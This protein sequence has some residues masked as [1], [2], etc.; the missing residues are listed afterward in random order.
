MDDMIELMDANGLL[1]RRLEAYA[2]FRLSPDLATTSRLRARVLAVAHR[3][4]SLARADAA[5]SVLP[6]ADGRTSG[7]LARDRGRA[8]ARHRSRR[9]SRAAG[10]FLAASLATAIVV[11]GVS[12]ARP[13]GPLYETRL[14]AETLTLPGDP[15]ARAVAELGRLRDRLR[16]VGEADRA[17]DAAGVMAALVAYEAILEQASAAAIAS[18]DDVAAAVLE[19][20]VARN[21]EVLRALVARVPANAST[22]ISRAVD[23]AIVRSTDTVERISTSRPD[24]GNDDGA[25]PGLPATPPQAT[26]TPTA[27]PTPEPEHTATPKSKP[28]KEPAPEPAATVAPT[29]PPDGEATPKPGRTPDRAPRPTPDPDGPPND[30]PGKDPSGGGSQGEGD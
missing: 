18:G 15:S 7:D 5:L 22:P 13:G 4:A 29:E 19:T 20:G 1:G 12:A 21:V 28:T 23:A 8:P 10:A 6:Q 11:G 17:G 3:Q 24:G 30:P 26:K 16:E 25:A 9:W 14:W 2:E 27:E